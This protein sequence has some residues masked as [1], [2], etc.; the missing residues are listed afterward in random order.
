MSAILVYVTVPDMPQ[1]ERIA[2][3]VVGDRLAACANMLPAMQSVY[4]W[5]GKIETA[6]EVV[7]IFKTLDTLFAPLCAKVKELHSYETPCIISVP[8]AAGDQAYLDW[9]KAETKS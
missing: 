3:A 2:Q 5:Q 9:I 7:L 1:A 6:A 8:I 4:H